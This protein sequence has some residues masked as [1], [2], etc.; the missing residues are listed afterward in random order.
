MC[1]ATY[2]TLPCNQPFIDVLSSLPLRAYSYAPNVLC[3]AESC[4]ATSMWLQFL[5]SSAS[6]N[7]VKVIF[8]NADTRSLLD[9][10]YV[11]PYCI[12]INFSGFHGFL[13]KT[14]AKKRIFLVFKKQAVSSCV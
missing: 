5:V 4:D 9:G 13:E 7:V 12:I 6:G 1:K 2:E 11:L 3:V 14:A 8:D 10:K